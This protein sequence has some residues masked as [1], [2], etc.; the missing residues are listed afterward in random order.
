M[1]PRVG[2][3]RV[4]AAGAL[5][6]YHRGH[7]DRPAATGSRTGKRRMLIVADRTV[8]PVPA[9]RRAPIA[10][11]ARVLCVQSSKTHAR[12]AP[13]A[14][15]VEPTSTGPADARRGPASPLSDS[16][17]R[18]VHKSARHP[19]PATRPPVGLPATRPAG[20]VRRAA[21]RM[22]VTATRRGAATV[23]SAS[24]RS[25]GD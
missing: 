18:H 1:A 15:R 23:G 21:G 2:G 10:L 20:R 12:N 13:L 24:N 25:V 17:S 8:P 7:Q 19:G 5:P 6:R 4:R 16:R 14:L 9:V 3:E 22:P 11:T